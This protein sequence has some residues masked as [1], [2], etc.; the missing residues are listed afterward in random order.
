MLYDKMTTPVTDVIVNA[1]AFSGSNYSFSTMKTSNAREIKDE[2]K[3]HNK[4]WEQLEAAQ[5]QWTRKRTQ[6]LILLM[7]KII[8]KIFQNKLLMVHEYDVIYG[9]LLDQYVPEKMWDNIN[10]AGLDSDYSYQLWSRDTHLDTCPGSV[11]YAMVKGSATDH[12]IG[13]YLGCVKMD[14]N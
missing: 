3:R 6:S 14:I 9:K 10:C 8:R 13:I 5:S 7:K 11:C 1:R 4:A 2:Q 12:A